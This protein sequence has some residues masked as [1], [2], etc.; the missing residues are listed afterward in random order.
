[1]SKNLVNKNNQFVDLPPP[2]NQIDDLIYLYNSKKLK[3]C[4]K[5][6]RKFISK[7]LFINF[8]YLEFISGSENHF[9]NIFLRVI[10]L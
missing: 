4:E 9:L 10:L 5:L 3:N 6:A 7:Y 1:M 2:I 8:I